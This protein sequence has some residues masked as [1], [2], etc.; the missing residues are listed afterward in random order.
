MGFWSIRPVWSPSSMLAGILKNQFIIFM[1]FYSWSWLYFSYF[2]DPYYFCWSFKLNLLEGFEDTRHL[3][4]TCIYS[5]TY[6]IR[7]TST[8][9]QDVPTE[10]EASSWN[11]RALTWVEASF[12]MWATCT[13]CTERDLSDAHTESLADLLLA[14]ASIAYNSWWS[15]NFIFSHLGRVMLPL[16]VL[17]LQQAQIRWIANTK[18]LLQHYI[19]LEPPGHS[20][21][22]EATAQISVDG[23][24]WPH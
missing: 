17:H 6:I 24:I 9:P 12:T 16:Q 5:I 15:V 11:A 18:S 20:N 2:L 10:S 3:D 8:T 14:V 13:W 21:E 4:M 7:F 22:S 19:R 23:D 1:Y